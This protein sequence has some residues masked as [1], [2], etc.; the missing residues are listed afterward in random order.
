MIIFLA[1]SSHTGKT[2]LA[3][4]L[5]EAHHIPYLSIDHLK[6]SLIRSGKTDLTV[7]DNDKLTAELWPILREMVK[8]VIENGQDLIIE[9]CYIPF[10]WQNSFD[11]RYLPHIRCRWLIMEEGYIRSHFTDIRTHANVIEARLDDGDLSVEALIRDNAANL[12]GCLAH[13]CEYVLINDDTAP[14]LYGGEVT[15][16]E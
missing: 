2:F 3:Q 14:A 5:L 13:G 15:F 6:M 1:G 16:L 7:F 8:T 12:S 11:E 4:K 9:G 10:D